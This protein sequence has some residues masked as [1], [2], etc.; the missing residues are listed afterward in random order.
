MLWSENR[1]ELYECD[2]ERLR[3]SGNIF[4]HELH[5]ISRLNVVIFTASLFQ[6][7]CS[8]PFIDSDRT[9]YEY[10]AFKSQ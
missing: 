2:S 3:K 4:T 10:C 6:P 7:S 1:F 8:F 5:V 9:M